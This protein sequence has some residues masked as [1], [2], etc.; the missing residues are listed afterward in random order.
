MK[1]KR[2][3]SLENIPEMTEEEED[4]TIKAFSR[5]LNTFEPVNC[6]FYCRSS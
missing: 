2:S 1:E 4:E 6:Q 3:G 5:W